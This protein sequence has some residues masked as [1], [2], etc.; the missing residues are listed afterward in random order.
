MKRLSLLALIAA[1]TSAYSNN[2]LLDWWDEHGDFTIRNL[3]SAFAQQPAEI[4]LY[5][6]L[7]FLLGTESD[8]ILNLPGYSLV[9]EF[10]PEASISYEH[11]FLEVKPRFVAR[12]DYF[13]EGEFDGSEASDDEFYIYEWVA[14]FFLTPELSISYGREDLQW[15]PSFLLSPSNPFDSDNGRSEPKAEVDS[16]DYAKVIWT[17]NFNWTVSAIVNTDDGR[18]DY[19]IDDRLRQDFRDIYAL[20]VDYLFERGNA[21]VIASTTDSAE[22]IDERLGYYISYN[23]TDAWIGYSE[24]SL[25]SEDEE[26]LLGA[27][28]TFQSGLSVAAEY[29]YNSSGI[30][31]DIPETVFG[32]IDLGDYLT[33]LPNR[34]TFFREHYALLQI[35]QNDV[36]RSLDLLLRYT[37]N[38]DDKSNSLLG[39]AEYDLNDYVQLFTSA[40]LNSNGGGELDSLRE[41]WVQIGVEFSY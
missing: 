19:R 14:Q 10:R 24:G 5:E 29:F 37:H 15:G 21:A 25:S 41:Y 18:K 39:H 27:S 20:K 31:D 38:I 34:E 17:P 4:P 9:N 7:G 11:A 40:T 35:Y 1:H 6:G 36:Y 8:N 13:R 30:D 28:Y 2:A 26:L 12:R 33:S 3:S 23:L 22:D 16:A 32:L